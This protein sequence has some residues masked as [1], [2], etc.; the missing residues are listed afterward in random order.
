MNGR[1]GTL[2]GKKNLLIIELIKFLTFPVALSRLVLIEAWLVLTA[3][4]KTKTAGRLSRKKVKL[5]NIDLHIAVIEEVSKYF[6]PGK[7]NLTR[8]SLSIHNHLQRPAHLWAE[9]PV[10][11]VNHASWK[12]LDKS[13][14]SKFQKRYRR[15]LRAFDGFVVTYPTTFIDLF[16]LTNKPILAVAATRYEAPYTVSEAKWDEFNVSLA[17]R[18]NSGQVTLIANNKGDADYI[19][20]FTGLDVPVFPSLCG[21]KPS[22]SGLA[23]RRVTLAKDS[24]LSSSVANRTQGLYEPIQSLG[25]PYKWTDLMSCLEVFVIPQN[26]STMTLFELATAGMPVVVPGRG[27]FREMKESFFGVLDELTFSE[28]NGVEAGGKFGEAGSPANWKD[29]NYLD[30]WL[31]RSDF[32]DREL[33]PNVRVAE[34]YEELMLSE[35][36]ILALRAGAES[37]IQRRNEQIRNKAQAFVTGWIEA[38]DNQ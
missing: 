8:F 9:D 26:I 36:E 19:K 10:A 1:L 24:R 20:F 23:G 27:L 4:W 38:I 28:I 16:A 35:K 30:W 12:E 18:V 15:L 21:G 6:S 32:Y 14:I 2:R 3:F 29:H 5:L 17:S 34:S 11:I 7:T 31:D 13:K 37:A 33:M 22:W 25:Q